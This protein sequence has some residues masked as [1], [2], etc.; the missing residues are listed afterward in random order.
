MEAVRRGADR[1]EAHEKLRVHARAAAERRL[2]SGEPADLLD[3]I[4]AD[5]AFRLSKADLAD[6]ARPERLVGRAA[7]QV[8]A[9]LR[10]ELDPALEG[11]AAA[12]PAPLKV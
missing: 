3:R 8:D 2:A 7:E 4:A 11:V 9:F 10:E 6:A 12:E 5:P 1:Q